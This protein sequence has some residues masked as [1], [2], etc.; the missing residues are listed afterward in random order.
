MTSERALFQGIL[1]TKQTVTTT[2]RIWGGFRSELIA[3]K[4]HGFLI[5]TK[6]RLSQRR[7]FWDQRFPA[8]LLIRFKGYH[9]TVPFRHSVRLTSD[10]DKSGCTDAG[11]SRSW[12]GAPHHYS[13]TRS[14]KTA[15]H[16]LYPT[17]WGLVLAV[18]E[19]SGKL[20]L[21]ILSFWQ[22]LF[23]QGNPGRNVGT[24]KFVCWCR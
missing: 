15:N 6:S 1:G 22:A 19:S 8:S 7:A 18:R 4:R 2:L 16:R 14:C 23:F 11:P 3:L 9:H 10:S 5:S 12:P 20:I 17:G 24:K 21:S 13:R